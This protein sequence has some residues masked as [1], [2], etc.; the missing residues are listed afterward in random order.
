MAVSPITHEL[1]ADT[2]TSISREATLHNKTD[3]TIHIITWKS[4]FIAS[5]ETWIP[6]FIRKSEEVYSQNLSNWIT[7]DT[8]EFYIA[9]NEIKTINFVIDIPTNATPWGHYWAIFFKKNNSEQSSGT[10]IWI[11]LHYWVLILLKVTWEIN[12]EIQIGNP[13]IWG[14]GWWGSKV[15]GMDICNETWGDKS[16]NYYDWKCLEQNLNNDI[17]VTNTWELNNNTH[18]DEI[19]LKKDD[20]VVDLTNSEY[21]WKCINN[22]DE[23]ISELTWDIENIDLKDIINDKDFK[24]QISIPIKNEW[25]IHVEPSGKIVLVDE[26]WKQINNIWKK[27]IKN[28]KWAIIWEKIV[29]YIP[30]NDIWGNILPWTKRVFD[31]SFKWFPYFQYID[32]EK[33]LKYKSP[34]EYYTKKNLEKKVFLMPWERFA[35]RNN[36]KTITAQFN[37]N[38]IDE[39]WEIIEFNSAQDFEIQFKERFVSLNPYFFIVLAWIVILVSLVAVLLNKIK[40]KKSTTI[41]T[42]T[43]QKLKIKEL[44][45]KEKTKDILIKNKLKF[46]SDFKK[47]TKKDLLKIKWIWP[48]AIEEIEKALVKEKIKLNK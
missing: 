35:T 24:I 23:I 19:I 18:I 21:D 38:Y 48:K 17:L 37:I 29:D 47:K 10:N 9:P 14:S 32:W 8:P 11:N 26:Q 36:N 13:I 41:G 28:D 1:T 44:N 2:W 25:N 5:W 12:V 4:D 40:W 46:I 39:N 45:I 30:F 31:W 22:F 16:W 27:I 42:K 34:S 20:C 6:N 43:K 33:I 3:S 15:I 7:I